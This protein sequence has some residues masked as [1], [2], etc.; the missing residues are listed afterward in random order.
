MVS[1]VLPSKLGASQ[2]TGILYIFL[3]FAGY[4]IG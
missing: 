3:C 1:P 2:D 4:A